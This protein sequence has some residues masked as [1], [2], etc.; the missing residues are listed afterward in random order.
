MG[1]K[2]GLFGCCC[3]SESTGK[4][5]VEET[6]GKVEDTPQFVRDILNQV[7]GAPQF[8]QE[9]RGKLQELVRLPKPE[10][11]KDGGGEIVDTEVMFANGST[12]VGQ[13]RD[14]RKHGEGK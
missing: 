1:L 12:Y 10:I 6:F 8:D 5:G 13:M 2:D 3:S 11:N 9:Q 7:Q 4:G 14:K